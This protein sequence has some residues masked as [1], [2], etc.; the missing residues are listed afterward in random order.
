MKIPKTLMIFIQ[1]SYICIYIYMS[2]RSWV[3]LYVEVALTVCG[4]CRGVWF[5]EICHV[6]RLSL[7]LSYSELASDY[8]IYISCVQ[9]QNKPSLGLLKVFVSED[10]KDNFWPCGIQVVRWFSDFCIA[11]ITLSLSLSNQP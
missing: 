6:F 8:Y 7:L 11:P 10:C 5:G 9:N 3:M 1:A 2:N 4:S